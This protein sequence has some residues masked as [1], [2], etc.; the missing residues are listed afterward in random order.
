[1]FIIILQ[2]AKNTLDCRISSSQFRIILNIRS[3]S[4]LKNPDS[5]DSG[6]SQKSNLKVPK[7]SGAKQCDNEVETEKINPS[8]KGG[9]YDAEE[10]REEDM[11]VSP[12]YWCHKSSRSKSFPATPSKMS[13]SF[14]CKLKSF[15]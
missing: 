6:I 15:S 12:F 9:C 13:K 8:R 4:K 11:C 2:S 1:M 5:V 10:V 7:K 14:H 3:W